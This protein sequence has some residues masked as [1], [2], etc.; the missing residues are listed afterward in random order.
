MRDPHLSIR[1][2]LLTSRIC[3]SAL[4]ACE[5]REGLEYRKWEG[6]GRGSSLYLRVY[7]EVKSHADFPVRL[8]H[9]STVFHPYLRKEA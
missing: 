7:G 1:A 3:H 2:F 4:I 8:V 9:L 6:L 5:A